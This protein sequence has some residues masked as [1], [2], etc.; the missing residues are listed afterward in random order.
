MPVNA[1]MTD[2]ETEPVEKTSKFEWLARTGYAARGVVF[3]LI[4]ALALFS[5]FGGG[6][7]DTKNALDSLLQQPFGRIWLGLIG[8]GLVG[9]VAWRLAQSL[10][11][12]DNH[13][14]G[15]KSMVVRAALF[16]SAATYAGLALYAFTHA[17]STGGGGE[18]GGEQGMAAWAMSQPFGRF[19][20]GAIGIGLVIGGG[21]TIYKGVTQRFRRYLKLPSDR[22]GP[23]A[24]LCVYGLA[25]RGVVFAIVGIFFTYAA[26]RV[27]PQQAGSTADALEWI[28]QLPFGAVLY[29]AV[30]AGLA[31][32]G[33]YNFVEA[34]YRTVQTP[35]LDQARHSLPV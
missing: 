27:D 26:F 1:S 23:L 3:L 28:R 25:A 30:A 24:L 34:R 11:D 17:L 7:P 29:L 15:A 19:L 31:A 20:A 35:A 10:A 9:F 5:S 32:F 22:H 2:R 21:V 4:A 33:I 8:L 16:G 13:G 18:G 14:S 6:R 12:A